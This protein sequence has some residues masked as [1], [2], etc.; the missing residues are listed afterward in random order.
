[1]KHP[2]PGRDRFGRT[3]RAPSGLTTCLRRAA[4]G[5]AARPGTQVTS[6]HGPLRC[7]TSSGEECADPIRG[8]GRVGTLAI[9]SQWAASGSLS[10][11]WRGRA[12]PPL[13]CG[14]TTASKL[15]R[16]PLCGPHAHCRPSARRLPSCDGW[17][18]AARPSLLDG[19][20]RGTPTGKTRCRP[21]GSLVCVFGPCLRLIVFQAEPFGL[22][23]RLG[24]VDRVGCPQGAGRH[25]VHL[26]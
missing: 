15:R 24:F 22:D 18:R 6:V 4:H 23:D 5:F 20:G 1:M 10:D 8:A 11:S 3:L 14:L 19:A 7:A 21:V 9:C 13:S 16:R 26:L 17:Y 25:V 12:S 2:G